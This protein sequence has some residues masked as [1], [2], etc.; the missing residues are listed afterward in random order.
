MSNTRPIY[1]KQKFRTGR[2]RAHYP[3]VITPDTKFKEE[4]EYSSDII[5][6]DE[7]ALARV[8]KAY[9]LAR[10]EW[11]NLVGA[12]G[13]KTASLPWDENDDGTFRVRLRRVAR[14]RTGSLTRVKIVDSSGMPLTGKAAEFGHGSIIDVGFS[15]RVW[16]TPAL[17][18]G[19]SFMP[20]I[21]MLHEARFENAASVDD[22]GFE[23]DGDA[24]GASADDGMPGDDD[25]TFED[26]DEF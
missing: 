2:G 18:Y 15:A 13:K 6:P 8:K 4:G 21:V 24:D 5:L 20:D 9:A 12:K 19:V 11:P 1:L 23:V 10:K 16:F 22:Y 14:T 26:E 7:D 17:G 25:G 3:C